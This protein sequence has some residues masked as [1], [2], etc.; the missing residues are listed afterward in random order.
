[1]ICKRIKKENIKIVSTSLV[2]DHET[3]TTI[4][5]SFEKVLEGLG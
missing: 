3:V 5:E 4:L 2:L 1:M